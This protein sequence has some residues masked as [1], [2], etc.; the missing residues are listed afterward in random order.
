M[1]KLISMVKSYTTNNEKAG[2]KGLELV[3]STIDHMFEH[4]D[5]TP[6]AWLIGQSQATDATRFRAIIGAC[7]GGI[8]IKKDV[9]QPSGLFVTVGA[10][11]GKTEKYAKL[12]ACI[13]SHVSFRSV[14]IAEEILDKETEEKVYSI[15]AV[16]L[17]FA[18]RAVKEGKTLDEMLVAIRAAY[19]ATL[20]VV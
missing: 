10:N 2:V 18:K 11:A 20:I 8:A 3:K 14:V 1:A 13:D 17:T 6:L 7:V 12:V 4:G 15:D 16:A 5:W 19:A 9:K